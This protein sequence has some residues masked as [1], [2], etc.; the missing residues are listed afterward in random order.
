MGDLTVMSVVAAAQKMNTT[1][2]EVKRLMKSG[3]LEVVDRE[4]GLPGVSERSVLDF[5]GEKRGDVPAK[6][7]GRK[8]N[9]M[10]VKEA[11]VKMYKKKM[12][13]REDRVAPKTEKEDPVDSEE[14][15]TKELEREADRKDAEKYEKE[16]E[17]REET[18]EKMDA[19]E[20]PFSM[21]DGDSSFDID[22]IMKALFPGMKPMDKEKR[23]EAIKKHRANRRFTKSDLIEV[24]EYA[25]MKGK[26][27]VYD[28]IQ[29]FERRKA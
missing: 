18:G 27:A 20:K 26:L 7:P 17:N 4:T 12:E 1:Q 13:G 11:T 3:V 6:K 24:A 21:G 22:A 8:P 15:D 23:E 14:N 2:E 29:T 9:L 16:S 25:Y 28:S 19:K 10:S 5:I